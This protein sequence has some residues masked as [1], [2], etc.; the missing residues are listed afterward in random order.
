MAETCHSILSLTADFER[1]FSNHPSLPPFPKLLSQIS[2]STKTSAHFYGA[3]VHSRDLIPLYHEVI[4]WMLKR[5]LL[6]T[7]HLRVRVFATPALKERVRIRRELILARQ[8]RVRSRS[9]SVA[10]RTAADDS[11]EGHHHHKE[12][13]DSESKHSDAADSSPVDY[14]MSMSPKHARAQARKISPALHHVR[15]D[16]S[17]SLVYNPSEISEKHGGEEEE[18]GLFDEDLDLPS[19][20]GLD[21]KIFEGGGGAT[22]IPDPGRANAVER[23][24]LSAMSEDKAPNIARRFEQ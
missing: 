19:S 10:G 15:R 9:I 1:S 3:V 4:I 2:T 12:R 5:D 24:W 13:R 21:V 20:I 17:L 14:W 18:D 6:I 23:L 8:G 7:L 11:V 22:I 16:R